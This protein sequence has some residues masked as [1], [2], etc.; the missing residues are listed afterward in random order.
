MPSHTFEPRY[1]DSMKKI[2]ITLAILSI[3]GCGI[4]GDRYRN[5][6]LDYQTYQPA[7]PIEVPQEL[8]QQGDWQLISQERLAV[9]DRNRETAQVAADTKFVVPKPSALVIEQVS[10]EQIVSLVQ[11]QQRDVNPRLEKDGSGAELL[12]LDADFSVA[13][14]VTTDAVKRLPYRLIDLD[15]SIGT[16]FVDSQNATDDKPKGF[17]KRL[18]GSNSSDTDTVAFQIKMNRTRSGVEITV[19][20]DNQTL[21]DKSL[22][23]SVLS[24]LRDLL[25]Q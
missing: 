11:Y 22:T 25:D 1:L 16:Y 15:R 12:R 10:E 3:T 17:F 8:I 24:Q 13:W 4:L 20:N 21:A 5:R 19:L 23:T 18:F 9:T 14:A 7:N 6:S 2:L